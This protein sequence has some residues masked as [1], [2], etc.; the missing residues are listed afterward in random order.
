MT[1]SARTAFCESQHRVGHEKITMTESFQAACDYSLLAL[2][3]EMPEAADPS[4]GWDSHSQMIGAR[5]VLDILK[6]IHQPIKPPKPLKPE[7]LN[8]GV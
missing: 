3:E 8:Y 5:R 4:K 1:R 6:T 7:T 2:L